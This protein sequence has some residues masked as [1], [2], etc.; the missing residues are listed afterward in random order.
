ME[1]K[2]YSA[3]FMYAFYMHHRIADY[4]INGRKRAEG[5]PSRLSVLQRVEVDE[6]ERKEGKG[7]WR[8][9]CVRRHLR[10]AGGDRRNFNP[11]RRERREK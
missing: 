8:H 1:Y 10:R 6:I 5:A 3:K 7:L 2:Y 11:S 4:R 9:G